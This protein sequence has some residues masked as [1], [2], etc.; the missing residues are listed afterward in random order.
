MAPALAL[1]N[2]I[3]QTAAAIPLVIATRRIC[4]R[5]ALQGVGHATRA[6]LAGGIV[7]AAV[8]VAVCLVAPA[9]W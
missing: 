5:A 1:G 7:A 8:G 9:G 4:G 2:T 6:G 3:G